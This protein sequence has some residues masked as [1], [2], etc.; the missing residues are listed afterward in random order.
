MIILSC[1][2]YG[3]NLMVVRRVKHFHTAYI[4]LSI[5]YC[6]KSLFIL[7]TYLKY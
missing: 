1:Y 5:D 6:K 2:C 7:F 4:L 3:W